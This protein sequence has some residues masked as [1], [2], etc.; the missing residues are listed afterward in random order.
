MALT[1][2]RSRDSTQTTTIL[3]AVQENPGEETGLRFEKR[4]TRTNAYQS[5][6]NIVHSSVEGRALSLHPDVQH[7]TSRSALK[8]NSMFSNTALQGVIGTYNQDRIQWR[9]KDRS[10]TESKIGG[11]SKP[12]IQV[13]IPDSRR[14]QPLPALPFF[15]KSKQDASP[16]LPVDRQDVSP[17][18]ASHKALRDSIV[19]PLNQIQPQP[20]SLNC[21]RTSSRH[22]N[23][24]KLERITPRTN[25]TFALSEG[26]SDSQESDGSSVR[27]THSSSTSVDVEHAPVH[28]KLRLPQSRFSWDTV[29]VSETGSDGFR[30]PPSTLPPRRY[31]SHV[32]IEENDVFHR[33]CRIQPTRDSTSTIKRV[34]TLT[35]RSSKRPQSRRSL[36]ATPN[37]G[38]ID[39]AVTRS[40][41]RQ[42][43]DSKRV[44]SPTL[45]EAEDELEEELCSF[46]L[47]GVLE[48]EGS[49]N[50]RSNSSHQLNI[51]Y[52]DAAY[53]G[54]TDLPP[55]VPRKSSKRKST[56]RGTGQNATAM[57]TSSSDSRRTHCRSQ[58][59]H[60]TIA[61]PEYQRTGEPYE[62]LSTEAPHST[63]QTPIAPGDAEAVIYGI[64]D[65]L[66]HLE[67]LFATAV[68]NRGF[69]RMFKRHELALIKSTLR[70]MSAPA[71]EFREIAFPGHEKL[72]AEDLE[73][74]RPDEEY[75][76]TTYLQLHKRDVQI[77]RAIKAQIMKKCQPFL[78]AEV[79]CALL[80]DDPMQSARVDD[81]LWRI[82]SFCKIFGSGKGR[83]EDIVAQ[84]D[85]LRG[86][87]L[88]HQEAC[89]SSF[90]STDF[91]NDTLVS[92]PDHFGSCNEGGLSAEELFDMMELWTCLGVLLQGFEGRTVEARTAGVF[93]CTDVRGGDIDGEEHMLG[94]C[95]WVS[96][97]M[98]TNRA[99]VVEWCYHLL[100]HG[101]STVLELADSSRFSD[102]S[103]FEVARREGHMSWKPPLF[104][105]TRRNFLKEAASRVYEDQ[106]ASKFAEISTRD[107]AR[108]Q[109][110]L[111]MQKHINEIHRRRNSDERAPL[112]HMSQQRPTS[113]WSTVMNHLTRP[114]PPLPSN[115]LISHIPILRSARTSDI[116]ASV[117]EL[118][119]S[120][121]PP[122]HSRIVAQPLLPTPPPSS[123][124]SH[125]DRHSIAISMPSIEERPTPQSQ[126]SI[127]E[128][129]SPI[130][131]PAFRSMGPSPNYPPPPPPPS[132]PYTRPLFRPMSGSSIYS[133]NTS[134][135]SLAEHPAFRQQYAQ[136]SV[137][138]PESYDN[139]ADDAIY[140]IVEMGFTANQAR[141]A[142]R[143][144]DRGSG[145]SIDRAVELL[146]RIPI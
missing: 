113:V 22:Y 75:V 56:V 11:L 133:R 116:S 78:R 41:S 123:A 54:P 66:D 24:G 62:V 32:P 46:L 122:P 53:A 144:T 18:S 50:N 40:T 29:N 21:L 87:V 57:K 23:P 90:I 131:R 110:K 1:L 92:S 45:S 108:Q 86:G 85:W 10:P 139:T 44:T 67:D 99:T 96:D 38:A 25:N 106:I 91:M 76:V 101:L 31:V 146:L 119:D 111:R 80:H 97:G 35:R 109:S 136:M 58:T 6:K 129:P 128:L 12:R 115:N 105:G 8:L 143:A 36:T 17:P 51:F 94:K 13:V 68:V 73:M 48:N 118:P 9:H 142:L 145:L 127:P 19:S 43:L 69:Y 30:S 126:I 3:R 7:N 138:S 112:I 117:A 83:E 132:H 137:Y 28:T 141:E 74:I 134:G 84:M 98:P 95:C 120:A 15:V 33:T 39:K 2:L 121:T 130:A 107:L 65:S 102:A 20:M 5:S 89:T 72:R 34:P 88:A 71:W 52:E 93:E 4:D 135:S 16:T 60:L 49:G 125:R 140:R 63:V 124:P 55:A 100:S 82:W 27:S 64:L 26:L 14:D 47:G 79:S 81:A 103:V 61:I 59:R 104:G 42:N 77:I 37:M 114:H 70:R